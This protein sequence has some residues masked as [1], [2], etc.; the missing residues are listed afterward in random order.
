[1]SFVVKR[2][3]D[4]MYLADDA[5]IWTKEVMEAKWFS[6]WER[7]D[8]NLCDGEEIVEID[9]EA[10]RAKDDEVVAVDLSGGLR[11]PARPTK[12]GT[13]RTSIH[14]DPENY[15]W[16]SK[17]SNEKGGKSYHDLINDAIKAYIEQES[18]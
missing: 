2:L 15:A 9:D 5:D 13:R 17:K 8:A 10:A 7:A 14:L 12:L 1:M 4:G 16:L 11:G 3:S 18:K 6:S